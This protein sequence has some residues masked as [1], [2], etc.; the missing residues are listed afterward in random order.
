LAEAARL[1]F[2]R[3]VTGPHHGAH[4]PPSNG[5]AIVTAGDIRAALTVSLAE[6]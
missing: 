4:A 6:D 2:A 1:G 5:G 3:L